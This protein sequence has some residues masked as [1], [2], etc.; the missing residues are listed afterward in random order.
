M[1][2]QEKDLTLEGQEKDLTLEGQEKDL[3][4]EGQEKELT[5]SEML[6]SLNEAQRVVS[7]VAPPKDKKERVAKEVK[8]LQ[9]LFEAK[10][11]KTVL[12]SDGKILS[13]VTRTGFLLVPVSVFGETAMLQEVKDVFD[14]SEEF[15]LKSVGDPESNEED[16]YEITFTHEGEKHLALFAI[17]KNSRKA[18]EEEKVNV[19][20]TPET[21][22]GQDEEMPEL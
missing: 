6:A 22:K 13:F 7:V 18:K 9:K 10:R 21:E 5:L 2:D 12:V 20:D 1:S 8:R 14:A 17:K 19:E 4:L 15:K 16:N 11:V 3:T